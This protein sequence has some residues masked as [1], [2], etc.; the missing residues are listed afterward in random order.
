MITLLPNHSVLFDCPATYRIV[1]QG[2]IAGSLSDRLEGMAIHGAL[3]EDGANLSVL[4]G[5]LTDQSALVGVLYSLYELHFP[6]I[7]LEKITP[8]KLSGSAD[9]DSRE[10]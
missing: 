7:A 6:L 1:I 8:D 5:E 9:V 2:R 10:Q 4:V 3:D